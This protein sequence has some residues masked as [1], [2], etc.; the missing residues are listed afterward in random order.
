[1]EKISQ[2]LLEDTSIYFLFEYKGMVD[3]LRKLSRDGTKECVELS[4]MQVRPGDVVVATNIAGRGTDLVLSKLLCLNG[5]LH[6]IMSYVP[7]NIRVELQ[8]FGRSGR[9]GDPGS[10]RLI[11]YHVG[12]VEIGE[13]SGIAP[14]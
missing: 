1:L 8:G 6:V 13:N 11:T 4:Q 14:E 9:Q 12:E 3:G 7:S 5:G 10:G 2:V